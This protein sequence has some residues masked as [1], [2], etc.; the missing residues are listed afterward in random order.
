MKDAGIQVQMI[1]QSAMSINIAFLV[2]NDQI[3][4]G[5]NALHETFFGKRAEPAAA[6][7]VAGPA[8]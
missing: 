1:S 5:V 6:G 8:R 2:N 7:A 3:P 4:A